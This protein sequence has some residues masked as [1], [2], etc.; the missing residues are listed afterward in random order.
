[1][2]RTPGLNRESRNLDEVDPGAEIGWRALYPFASHEIQVQGHRYHYLDEHPADVDDA[3]TLLMVHGNPTWSFHWRNL[4]EHWRT[5]RRCVAPDHLGSGLS[6]KPANGA[7]RLTDHVANLVQLI[8]SLDLRDVTLVAQDWGGAIGL[9]A[10]LRVPE[11]FSRFVL[12]NTGAFPP[13]SIPWRIRACRLP[14]L[15]QLMMRG[16]NVFSLA[17]LRMTM[18]RREQLTLPEQQG[19]L[20]PYGSWAERIGVYQFVRDI[21]ASRRHPT[22]D[23]LAQIEAQ[24]PSLADRPM[25]LIWGMRDWCFTPSCLARFEAIFP[26]A[27]VDRLEDAGHWVVED[28]TEQVVSRMDQF[29]LTHPIHQT[30]GCDDVPA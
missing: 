6:D 3:E 26:N 10:A 12:L 7:Y 28:A 14:V 5:S 18:V 16:L 30:T 13:P 2:Q 22:Y 8:E 25:Q 21:P 11:R 19:Y 27:E 4:I 23:T 24:L 9:G 15:G 1:M 29:F 17:A 20:A